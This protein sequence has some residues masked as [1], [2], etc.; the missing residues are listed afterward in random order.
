MPRR[1]FLQVGKF[2]IL[3]LSEHM[4][5][6]A[7]GKLCCRLIKQNRPTDRL[8]RPVRCMPFLFH[9]TNIY[10]FFFAP[11]TVLYYTQKYLTSKNTQK[12]AAQPERRGKP[13]FFTIPPM[14]RIIL[15]IKKRQQRRRIIDFF[16]YFTNFTNDIITRIRY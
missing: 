8:A 6:T 10:S 2:R 4:R 15:P 7:S 13:P 1:D 11:L 3:I 16:T 14:A 5:R 9:Q 12:R